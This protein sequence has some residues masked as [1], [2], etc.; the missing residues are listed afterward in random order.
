MREQN[1]YDIARGLEK[2]ITTLLITSRF[3]SATNVIVLSATLRLTTDN[4]RRQTELLQKV[5]DLMSRIEA[6]ALFVDLNSRLKTLLSQIADIEKFGLRERDGVSPLLDLESGRRDVGF[7]V[8]ELAVRWNL[9]TTHSMQ[10]NL[11]LIDGKISQFK[12]EI[13]PINN[14]SL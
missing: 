6:T 14:P 4:S 8:T 12:G 1:C 10:T 11:D 5:D 3:S 13:K 2:E 9:Y 7:I